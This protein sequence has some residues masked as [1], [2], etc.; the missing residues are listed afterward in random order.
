M[1]TLDPTLTRPGAAA[2]WKGAALTAFAA[3]LFPRVN[4]VIYD[5][6]KIWQLDPEARFMA[7][8]AV[9]VALALFAAVGLPLWRTARLA[10]ASLVVGV[11]ALLGVVAF[12][13]SAPIA[14]GGLAV[15]LGVE[16]VR[17]DAAS[18]LARAGVLVGALAVVVGAV[19]WLA[20]V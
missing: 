15:T 7:P 5:H 6:E 17:R 16:A 3:V 20:G 10:V 14:L 13:L 12:W 9:A 18:R 19:M 11:V 1:T 2:L 8:L 4:A